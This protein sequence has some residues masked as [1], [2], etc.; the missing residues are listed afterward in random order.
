MFSSGSP[1]QPIR[2]ARTFEAAIEHILEGIESDRLRAGD[3]LPNEAELSAALEISRPTLRQALRVL[4]NAGLL[5]VRRGAGGGILVVSDLVP[6]TAISSFV[7]VEEDSVVD[8]LCARRVLEGAVT[9][10]A[11]DVARADDYG[12]IERTIDLLRGCI[13]NREHVVRADAM[14]HRAV[15]R[16]AR[17]PALQGAMRGIGRSLA[18]LRDAYPGGQREDRHTLAVH[19]RQLEAMRARDHALLQEVLHEHFCMLEEACAA[20]RGLPRDEIFAA[21]A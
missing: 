9:H 8:V 7:A 18:P 13:G 14:F 11:A 16:A 3:R 12:E 4:E 19:E 17:S 21:L 10:R 15:V 5:Q 20:A 1:Y 2:A 6:T